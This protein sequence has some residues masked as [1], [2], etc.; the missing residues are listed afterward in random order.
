MSENG[1]D[2]QQDGY[3]YNGETPRDN[4]VSM[5]RPDLAAMVAEDK[6]ARSEAC[7]KAVDA[8]LKEHNCTVMIFVHVG[9]YKFP[10]G[11]VISGQIE[12]SIEAQEVKP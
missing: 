3:K 11:A 2:E 9:E 10:I 6:K 12:L 7:L 8:A 4:V 1:L 5:V